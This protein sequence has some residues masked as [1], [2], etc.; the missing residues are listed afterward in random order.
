MVHT[1]VA[2]RKYTVEEYFEMEEKSEIRHEFYDGEV[3]AMAGTTLNHNDIVDNVR[4][5]LKGFFKPK[6]CRIF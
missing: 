6:G 2:E 3:F 4:S 1:Q 5:I